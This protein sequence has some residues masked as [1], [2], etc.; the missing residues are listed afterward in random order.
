MPETMKEKTNGRIRVQGSFTIYLLLSLLLIMALIFTLTESARIQCI[1]T[2]L[3]GLTFLAADS[4]F[5][6]YSREIFEEYG[7]MALWKSEAGF[8]AGFDSYLQHNLQISDTGEYRDVDLFLVRPAASAISDVQWLTDDQGSPFVEQVC[9]YMEYYLVKEALEGLL[10]MLGV[11]DESEKIGKFVDKINSYKDVFLKVSDAVS[12]IQQHVDRARSVVNNPKTLLG[13]M[14]HSMERYAQTGNQVFIAQFNTHYWNL[15]EGRDEMLWHMRG[16]LEDSDQYRQ[17]AAQAEDAIGSLREELQ[18]DQDAYSEETLQAISGQLDALAQKAADPQGLYY[19]VEENQAA[20]ERCESDLES[21]D[22][23]LYNLDPQDMQEHLLDYYPMVSYYNAVFENF[24]LETL[25][26]TNHSERVQR[27]KSGFLST[28]KDIF[29]KGLLEAVAGTSVSDRKTD[30]SAFPSVTVGTGGLFSG[31]GSFAS[32]PYK[33]LV[34]AEYIAGHFGN[35]RE[36][37]ENTELVYEMEYILAGK[38]SDKENLRQVVRE[39]VLLRSG[40]NMISLMRDP[41]KME[42]AQLLALAIIGFTGIDPLIE[43]LKM[44]IMSIWSLAEGLSDVKALLLGNRVALIK[45]GWQWT[46][47]VNGLKTFSRSVV[48]SASD[49]EGMDYTDYLKILLL[50]RSNALLA[51]RTMDM[52]QANACKR[53]DAGFRMKEC[54]NRISLTAAFYA[55]SLFASFLFVRRAVGNGAGAYAFAIQQGYSYTGFP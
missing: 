42:E 8:L 21:L 7:I 3:K 55:K 53:Y 32:A 46:V 51:F 38:A 31:T 33:R 6:E 27:E 24:N 40:L 36:Q 19:R 5:A 14:N 9:D 54:I 43:S 22:S 26:L 18:S 35:Y 41:D 16:I 4:C 17:Y 34:L 15:G 45:E 48:P 10:E 13:N 44:L 47:S 30:K 39:L 37:K 28:I 23:L 11:F 49:E 2:R 12:S 1:R 29:T 25:G 52:I 50:K 20:A